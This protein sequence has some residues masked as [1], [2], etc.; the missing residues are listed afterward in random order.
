MWKAFPHYNVIIYLIEIP[1]VIEQSCYLTVSFFSK[2]IKIDP[3]LQ[4]EF[5]EKTKILH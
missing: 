5:T 3:I 4:W 2:A 1:L